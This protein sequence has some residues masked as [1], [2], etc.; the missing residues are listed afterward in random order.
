MNYKLSFI[1]EA[2]QDYKALDGSQRKIVDKA[3]KRILIN[4]LPNTEGG[5][6]KPLSNLSD[7]K[8]AGLMKIKLKSSGLR[9]VYKLENQMTKF[10]SLLSV[11]EPNPK[12]IKMLKKE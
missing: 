3:L 4:P 9:I 2:I 6:G 5:Y 1:K 10:L 11:Q 8:L 12:S 7:S